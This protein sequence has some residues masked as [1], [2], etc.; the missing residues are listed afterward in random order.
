M[1][2]EL[3]EAKYGGSFPAVNGTGPSF[4]SRQSEIRPGVD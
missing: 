3:G 2:F 1:S 4:E